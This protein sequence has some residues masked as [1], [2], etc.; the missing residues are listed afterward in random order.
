MKKL[1]V[2]VGAA[3][4]AFAAFAVDDVAWLISDGG[5]TTNGYADIQAAFDDADVGD[6]VLLLADYTVENAIHFVNKDV[7]FDLGGCRLSNVDCSGM[8]SSFN[9]AD[10]CPAVFD[11]TN[12]V[13]VVTN[14]VIDA[15]YGTTIKSTGATSSIT[16]AKSA[17]LT[18]CFA[19]MFWPRNATVDIYGKISAYG[20]EWACVWLAE[21]NCVINVHDGAELV[22]EKGDVFRFECVVEES[23]LDSVTPPVLNIY[24]GTMQASGYPIIHSIEGYRYYKKPSIGRVNITGGTFLNPT[25]NSGI[26]TD[27]PTYPFL[28]CVME[29]Y[30]EMTYAPLDDKCTAK[31]D[32]IKGVAN[33]CAA[34]FGPALGDD[35]YYTIRQV[36]VNVISPNGLVTNAYDDIYTAFENVE[37]GGIVKLCTSVTIDQDR[38]ITFEDRQITLDL[39]GFTLFN[40][41]VDKTTVKEDLATSPAVLDITNSVFVVTN[42]IIDADNGTAIKSTGAAGHI[43]IAKSATL[44][45]SHIHLFNPGA[46]TVDIYGTLIA[47]PEWEYPCIWMT[48]AGCEVNVYDSAELRSKGDVFRI[49]YTGDGTAPTLNIYGGKMESRGYSVIYV[50]VSLSED[51]YSGNVTIVGGTF[52]SD[53]NPAFPSI[54]G[55][56]L[57]NMN[58]NELDDTCKASFKVERGLIDFCQPG[59]GPVLNKYGYYNINRVYNITFGTDGHG[60]VET[61]VTNNVGPGVVVTVFVKPASGYAVDEVS[62][63]GTLLSGDPMTFEMP[64]QDVQVFAA[65][66]KGGAVTWPTEWPADAAEAVKAKFAD[67][68]AANSGVD[69]TA[70]AVKSAFLLNVKAGA[71]LPA[72]K[73]ES[74]AVE[75]GKASVVVGLE[76]KDIES[77]INGVLY[78]D[79]T[80]DLANWVTTEVVS[81]A[82][83]DF[84]D[85]K[86]TFEVESAPF[87]KAC[88]GFQ[89]PQPVVR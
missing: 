7:T 12:S 32:N 55:R 10:D 34:G 22:S 84:A 20:G 9:W 75:D 83:A 41:E 60:T 71:T 33:F 86:A 72:F 69:F 40:H 13:F 51:A 17:E 80:D 30:R 67:W 6:K 87:I 59:Y 62:A 24:G 43:T 25:F 89:V 28:S 19:W 74:I 82:D 76:G 64:E 18:G 31:F 35:G 85:G 42:G 66:K 2:T 88:I 70:D 57:K 8:L 45:G 65:F 27:D 29:V 5:V 61:S 52:D 26:K 37:D 77:E 56:K 50:P 63:S 44:S 36:P 23:E 1:M 38:P 81:E 46:A 47:M 78:I 16:I 49:E 4:A 15:N 11:I 39:G 3:V 79:A 68:F 21:P 48:E 54:I 53:L 73:I 58:Y 14:G